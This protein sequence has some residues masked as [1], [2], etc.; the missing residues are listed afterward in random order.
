MKEVWHL[1][2]YVIKL[3]L[4]LISM[5]VMDKNKNSIEYKLRNSK[6]YQCQGKYKERPVSTLWTETMVF[7]QNKEFE[8]KI[9]NE[10]K[11]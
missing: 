4:I 11:D 7:D 1:K 9:V 6:K 10:V 3:V 8:H 5:L 2:V